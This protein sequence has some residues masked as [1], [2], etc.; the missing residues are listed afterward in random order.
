MASLDELTI[1]D[2]AALEEQV[3]HDG[4]TPKEEQHLILAKM[5]ATGDNCPRC[6]APVSGL[7]ARAEYLGLAEVAALTVA[8][9]FAP[10]TDH[11]YRCPACKARLTREATLLGTQTAWRLT[12]AADINDRSPDDASPRRQA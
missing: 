4:L 3:G 6:D 7:T 10:G 12:D 5:M 8:H 1:G 11:D 9:L 2:L